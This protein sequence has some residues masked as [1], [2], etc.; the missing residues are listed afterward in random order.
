MAKE[1]KVKAQAD[2]DESISGVLSFFDPN[3]NFLGNGLNYYISSQT[4]DKPDQ[5][6]ENSLVTLGLGTSF[7]Q[8]RNVEANLGLFAA[9][10]DLSTTSDASDSLK[11]KLVNIMSLACSTVSHSIKEIEN[12]CQHQEL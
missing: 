6:Y 9:Y 10:D 2:I 5:G 8:Y 3:Y 1:K 12:L 7:E 11:N 4:S